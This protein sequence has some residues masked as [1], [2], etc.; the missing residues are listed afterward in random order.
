[1]P[2]EI[3]AMDGCTANW[4]NP[5]LVITCEHGGNR[6]P[7]RYRDLFKTNQVLLSTHR[8]F[9]PGALIMAK[10]LATAFAAPLVASTVSRLLVDLNRS[11]GHPQLHYQAIRKL[12]SG[13]RDII[14]KQYYQPYRTQAK[15]LVS[16]AIADHS[17][18]IHLSS[19]S[20]TP[21][22]NGKVRNADIGLLYDPARPYETA[23]CEQWKLAL[24][25]YAPELSV[26]RNYP[27]EGKGDGLT[28]W[29]RQWLPPDTYIGIELEVNQK[30]VLKAGRHWP[31]LRKAIVK[32]LCMALSK[33][34]Q[35]FPL[36]RNH[37]QKPKRPV[38]DK[39]SI[40]EQQE[41]YHEDPY[42]L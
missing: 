7:G 13:L 23:L 20:F 26:R 42:R 25:A 15:N 5:S 35:D 16:E 40:G 32:S 33:L 19:H 1:M 22:L 2:S 36:W 6:I 24:K 37:P 9:D 12:P 28:T 27:Y 30:H 34:E 10:E 39:V 14:V 11:V 38:S 8:G 18:V 41:H 4:G 3:T 29:F 31:G 17:Q 21:E